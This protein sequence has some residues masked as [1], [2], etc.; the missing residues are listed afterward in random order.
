MKCK[1]KEKFYGKN[2]NPIFFLIHWGTR[3]FLDCPDVQK[4]SNI[5][6]KAKQPKKRQ[7]QTRDCL[8]LK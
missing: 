4:Q 5:A 7:Q 1:K 2:K 6:K 3:E 8:H